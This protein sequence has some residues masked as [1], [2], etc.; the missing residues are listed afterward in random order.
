MTSATLEEVFTNPYGQLYGTEGCSEGDEPWWM[1]SGKGQER[2][3]L[4]HILELPTLTKPHST[5]KKKR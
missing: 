1:C 2:V 3:R 5:R 4:D